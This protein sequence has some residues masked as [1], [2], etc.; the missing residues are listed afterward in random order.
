MATQEAFLSA[1]TDHCHALCLKILTLFAIGLHV[2]PAQGGSTWFSSR[3]SRTLGPSGCTLRLLYYPSIP[4]DADYQP[5]IDIRA[6][7]HSD[8]GSITLLFQRPG[9]PGLEIL[10][11]QGVWEPVYVVPPGTE[12]DRSPPILVNIGDLLSY[13]TN[14]LLRSTVHRVTFPKG[15][16]RGGEDRYS[17]AFFCHPVDNTILEPVPS[18]MTKARVVGGHGNADKW[19]NMTAAEH[20]QERLRATYLS[21]KWDK[22]GLNVEASSAEKAESS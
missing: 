21:L 5:D 2:D 1:F 9:Q 16:K 3:H 12:N 10:T 15:A 19:E 7:A 14:G 13:W 8:Y 18:I 20:L 11:A 4:E 6:G 17:I 22:D